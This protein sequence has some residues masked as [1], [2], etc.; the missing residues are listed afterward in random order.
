MVDLA[1][2]QP[3]DVNIPLIAL[4]LSR[5]CRFNG[6]TTRFYSVAEHCCRLATLAANRGHGAEVQLWALLHDAH[7]AYTGDVT[8][9]LQRMLGNAA[10]DALAAAQ[11][12]WDEAICARLDFHPDVHTLQIV[13][14][15]DD[16]MLAIE[17]A[18]GVIDLVVHE[19]WDDLP[20]VDMAD[21]FDVERDAVPHW[22]STWIEMLTTLR[23]QLADGR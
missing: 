20:A 19:A 21:T 4:S 16:E 17:R 8:R 7:E 23:E 15:L 9:P 13:A 14:D 11:D 3:S 2:P 5:Q 18:S 12:A 1:D 6:C 22:R 10:R